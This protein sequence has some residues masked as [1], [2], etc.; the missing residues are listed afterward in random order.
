LKP[1]VALLLLP[2]HRGIMGASTGI[3]PKA[4]VPYLPRAPQTNIAAQDYRGPVQSP[5]QSSTGDNTQQPGTYPPGSARPSAAAP[6][7]FT[8]G[9]N[10]YNHAKLAWTSSP[11]GS[12]KISGGKVRGGPLNNVKAD[13][14]SIE[15]AARIHWNKIT[16]E[17]RNQHADLAGKGDMRAESEGGPAGAARGTGNVRTGY[18]PI[19]TD[20][21]PIGQ[22]QM[23]SGKVTQQS[24]D[25]YRQMAQA[26]QERINA[27]KADVAAT[28]AKQ[29][30]DPAGTVDNARAQ[31]SADLAKD[32]VTDIGG[33]NRTLNNKS[34]S[35]VSVMP[36]QPGYING[37]HVSIWDDK[38]QPV[39]MSDGSPVPKVGDGMTRKDSKENIAGIQSGL[40]PGAS[41]RLAAD[42]YRA[43]K[44]QTDANN[45]P[46]AP[47]STVSLTDQA[48]A[49]TAGKPNPAM[50]AAKPGAPAPLTTPSM[51]PPGTITGSNGFASEFDNRFSPTMSA[52]AVPVQASAKPPAPAASAAV[53]ATPGT[54]PFMGPPAN[55]AALAASRD[56]GI[57]DQNQPALTRFGKFNTAVAADI[58][59]K[60]GQASNAIVSGAAKVLTPVSNFFTGNS[61]E[62]TAAQA[63]LDAANGKT[64]APAAPPQ[65]PSSNPFVFANAPGPPPSAGNTQAASQPIST[66]TAST[67]YRNPIDIPIPDPNAMDAYRK[68]IA[69]P[70]P[71]T[72]P[73]QAKPAPAM[74]ADPAAAPDTDTTDP[75][76][77][78]P[79]APV[80][81]AS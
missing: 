66:A 68:S 26:G 60:V 36:G 45:A 35:G 38:G 80:P 11:D 75:K 2:Y 15:A 14:Q 28:R 52:P 76:N 70:A 8:T 22:N 42:R 57:V 72:G 58:G 74:N 29:I 1:L 77:K 56:Q 73:A 6:Q 33:G 24:M 43:I 30:L 12:I 46:I 18:Q 71:V 19:G 32:G 69:A 55:A 47:G 48:N 44:A 10:G 41:D 23:P 61:D 9:Q 5:S 63:R 27:N 21:T 31:Q 81:A 51:P 13:T 37:P 16:P 64:P 7:T 79:V 40:A 54:P 39:K 50:V 53:P 67:A 3:P 34:G 20:Y 59:N 65:V 49:Y 78:K 62:A 17:E 4:V 25:T